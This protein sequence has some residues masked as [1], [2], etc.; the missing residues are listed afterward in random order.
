ML[1]REPALIFGI[2][3]PQRLLHAKRQWVSWV[4]RPGEDTLCGSVQGVTHTNAHLE[5]TA[6]R[7]HCLRVR[8]GHDDFAAW[9]STT[10]R[11]REGHDDCLLR[12]ARGHSPRPPERLHPPAQLLIGDLGL[13]LQL[14]ALESQ[15]HLIEF[16]A[17]LTLHRKPGREVCLAGAGISV[18]GAKDIVTILAPVATTARRRPQ[19][20]RIPGHVA[21]RNTIYAEAA[22]ALP[23]IVILLPAHPP[24]QAP[25][26]TTTSTATWRTR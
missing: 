21:W 17:A 2:V 19:D 14:Q 26:S 15:E 4:Y 12:M 18:P 6:C 13:P 5:A 25:T 8:R 24:D 22:A 9:R 23:R 16:L 1:I 10:E 3:A 11:I 20:D 7:P